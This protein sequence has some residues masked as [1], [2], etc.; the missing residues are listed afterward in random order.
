MLQ[1]GFSSD[2]PSS[3]EYPL[4]RRRWKSQ[5]AG[6]AQTGILWL[7][8]VG[9]F[10]VRIINNAAVIEIG[11]FGD[12][13]TYAMMRGFSSPLDGAATYPFMPF[14]FLNKWSSN[15]LDPRLRRNASGEPHDRGLGGMT[16]ART[17]RSC[18]GQVRLAGTIESQMSGS[19]ARHSTL[20]AC[21][22]GIVAGIP[23]AGRRA[24]APTRHVRNGDTARKKACATSP[25]RLESFLWNSLL[26]SSPA[27]F[28]H[29]CSY[30]RR[31]VPTCRH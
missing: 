15:R 10:A 20:K 18:W 31:R 26:A 7:R 23:T 5:N 22:A 6:P 1:F 11:E 12:S 9:V 30:G 13:D 19:K 21:C 29:L 14:F 2:R 8:A 17:A 28:L 25:G 27:G 3:D 16:R 4:G 24:S